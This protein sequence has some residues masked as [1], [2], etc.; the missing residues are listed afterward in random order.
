MKRVLLSLIFTA[1][2]LLAQAQIGVSINVGAPEFFG[3]INIGNESRPP[4]IYANPVIVQ[5]PA[6]GYNAAPMYLRVPEDHH[7]HWN[8]YCAQYNACGRQV[9]FVTDNWYRN[10]YAPR[11]AREHEQDRGYERERDHD[12]EHDRDHDN[13]R[14]HDNERDHDN[15][16]D[17]DHGHDHHDERN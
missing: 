9:Y 7:R 8:R 11:Y 2:P 10:D 17:H 12:R 13:G 5:A 15:G 3:Q 6:Y 16:R 1:A 14:D 4:V